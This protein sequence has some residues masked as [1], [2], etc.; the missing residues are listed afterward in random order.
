MFGKKWRSAVLVAVVLAVGVSAGSKSV[1]A[2]DR[3]V[4]GWRTVVETRY[5]AQQTAVPVRDYC[6]RVTYTVKTVTVAV[7]VPV[8]KLVRLY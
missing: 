5:V 3:P 4:Y 2:C 8:Q 6:G 1:A 7:P